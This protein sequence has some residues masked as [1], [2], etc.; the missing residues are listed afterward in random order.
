MGAMLEILNLSKNF[1]QHAGAGDD[2]ILVLDRINFHVQQNQFVC[3]LGPS[4]CGKTTLLRIV[5]GLTQADEGQV[6]I[7]GREVG[8][9]GRDR[10]MVFQSYGL[11][12]WR[13]VM[14]NVEFGLEIQGVER[15]KRREICQ[16]YID[17]VGLKGFETHYP[18]QISG[19]MQQRTALARA[20]SKDPKILLMDEPFAAVDMQTREM[21]QDELLKIWTS[22]QTTVL[23]V[24]HSVD[25]AIYLGDRVIVMA[26]RPGHVS[27]DIETGLPRPRYES[28]VKSTTRFQEIRKHVRAALRHDTQLEGAI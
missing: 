26:A 24:T 10:A 7:E 15:I 2:R 16:R 14:G 12:P 23:F 4:G 6:R 1:A 8:E 28:D 20:F 18:H 5:A 11:L 9:P 25:E 17:R 19:G 21:L 13:T 22:M 3:L 27:A